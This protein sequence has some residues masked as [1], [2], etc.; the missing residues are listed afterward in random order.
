MSARHFMPSAEKARMADNIKWADPKE[1]KEHPFSLNVYGRDGCADLVDSIRDSGVREPLHVSTRTGERVVISGHR[2]RNAAIEAGLKEVPIIR[3]H[4]ESE[5]EEQLAIIQFNQQRIKTGLQLY[6]EGR[7]LDRIYSELARQRQGTRTDLQSNLLQNFA[8]GA[9][10]RLTRTKVAQAIGLGSGEQWR[11]LEY[12]AEHKP[13]LLADIGPGGISIHRAFMQSRRIEPEPNGLGRIPL[14]KG[15]YRTLII[16]P[17]WPMEKSE[18][19]VRPQQGR[20]LDYPVLR[21]DQIRALP[22]REWAAEDTCHVYLWATHRFLPVAFDFFR[23]WGVNYHCLLTWRKNVGFTP[24]SW[25][26]ST[27]H[28]L[29]GWL[30]SFRLLEVGQRVDFDAP[31]TEH[32]HKPAKFYDLV[33]AVSPEPRRDLFSR[34]DHEGF[35]A[36]GDEMGKF[37]GVP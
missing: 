13:E 24:F 36:W 17:P 28:C 37:G 30:G 9:D 7:G 20:T 35:Q 12:V 22:I 31:V 16:D 33:R 25:M 27:E 2:R 23:E 4:F 26:F 21:L 15:K 34:E 10:E 1:L 11:K 8:E 29:F 3:G 18:R 14:P 5:L 32:S 19:E 6:N